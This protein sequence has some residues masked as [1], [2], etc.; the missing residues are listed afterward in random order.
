[1]NTK[2]LTSLVLLVVACSGGQTAGGQGGESEAQLKKLAADAKA[3]GSSH[4]DA[5]QE[6]GWYGDGECDRFCQDVDSLD[7]T[8]SVGGDG[9]HCAEFVEIANGF[10][11]RVADDPCISQDPDC[12]AGAP[13]KAPG[14]PLICPAIALEADGVCSAND[15]NPCLFYED[16]DCSAGDPTPPKPPGDPLICPA[17]ALEADGVCSANDANPCLFYED[18]DCSAAAPPP[19]D[20]PGSTPPSDP[21][22][23]ACKAGDPNCGACATYI[24]LPDGAC[25]RAPT[26]PCMF[27]DPDCQVK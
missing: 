22:A 21:S 24:E 19:S 7:C 5:C 4:G 2:Y 18:P 14:D 15:A 1:M 16:P 12:A 9:V 8:P 10:C 11:S 27:Q 17:I 20:A 23:P 6:H 26:D 13:P 3:K 25:K